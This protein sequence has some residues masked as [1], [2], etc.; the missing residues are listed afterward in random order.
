[1][2]VLSSIWERIQR[3]LFPFLE[4][5]LGPLTEKQQELISILEIIRIED[6]IFPRQYRNCCS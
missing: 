1:M 4:D 3:S 6:S 5:E 2:T